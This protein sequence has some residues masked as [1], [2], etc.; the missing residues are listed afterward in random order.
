MTV[1][2]SDNETNIEVQT[3]L[4][5]SELYMEAVSEV[6]L[7][8]CVSTRRRTFQL[9]KAFIVKAERG[10]QTHINCKCPLLICSRQKSGGCSERGRLEKSSL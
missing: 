10:N 6:R 8:G 3:S 5:V 1:L 9:L 7:V 2:T 4:S